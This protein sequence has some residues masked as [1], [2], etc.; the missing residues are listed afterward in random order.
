[1]TRE[2]VIVRLEKELTRLEE[3]PAWW[4]YTLGKKAGTKYA[5]FLVKQIKP[6]TPVKTSQLAVWDVKEE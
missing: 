1:M 3:R 2:E 6:S 4:S 5:L